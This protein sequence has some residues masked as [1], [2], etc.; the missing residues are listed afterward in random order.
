MAQVPLLFFAAAFTYVVSLG[1]GKMLIAHLGLK[2]Y[3]SEEYFFGFVLGSTILSTVVF[4][5]TAAHLA[6]TPVFL[7]AGLAIVALSAYRGAYRFSRERLPP[8]DISWR[9]ALGLLY[10]S[11]AILY[12]KTALLPEVQA[13]AVGYHI[14][15]PA[16]YLREHGFTPTQRNMMAN[17]SE[18]IEMLFT[19]A[20]AF[21]KH[22]AGAMVHLVYTLVLPFGIL[23]WGRRFALPEV[24]AAGA[25]L[26][27][28]SPIVGRLGT[29]GYID[30]AVA[31]IVFAVFYLLT[32][33]RENQSTSLLVAA[34]LLAG[35]CY[36]AKYTAGIAVP[37]AVGFVLFDRL[38]AR[39]PWW[40]PVLVT[41]L[42]AII[43]MAPYLVKNAV[44]TGNPFAPFA[45]R[46]FPNPAM[47]PS[48]EQAYWDAMAYWSGLKLSQLPL[49]V[50]VH[51]GHAAGIIGPVF[52][53]TPLALLAARF[54]AGRLLLLTGSVFLVPYVANIGTRFL[55]PA[56]PF[57]ALALA[58]AFGRWKAG[59]AALVLIHA[60]LSWPRIVPRYC[61]PWCWR[62][63]R[64]EWSSA[65][66]L[67]PEQDYLRSH[68][69]DYQMSQ[70]IE[71]IVPPGEFV[72]GM[73]GVAEAYQSHEI[74]VSWQSS[75]GDRLKTALLTPITTELQPVWHFRFEFPEKAVRKIRLLQQGSSP[76]SN[77]SVTELRVY[78]KGVEV[79]RESSW[80]PRTSH[81]P[82][83]LQSA[84]DNNPVTRW[85]SGEPLR[86]RMWLQLD[87]GNPE[88]I[89][90]VVVESSAD[91]PDTRMRLEFESA[92]GRWTALA[93]DPAMQATG[94]PPGL[95]AAAI[96]ALR[97][98]HVYWLLVK[99]RD[100]IADAVNPYP[101][102]WGLRLAAVDQDWRL[103]TL[104]RPVASNPDKIP[105]NLLV[106][107]L[108][109][110]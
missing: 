7:A 53:L 99:D 58:C 35:F 21:G 47:T 24:G 13:D 61:H 11:F 74:V 6:Y 42:F 20:F 85:N 26:L 103:Y 10:A 94:T 75:F 97:L 65:L 50:T 15:L 48:L 44:F 40:R 56:L 100:E 23:S 64:V 2:L 22:S 109:G 87:F 4:L 27:F 16:R 82:W 49:E 71:K 43:M 19:F 1:A 90:S 51:G 67:T 9:I 34:G 84:F 31:S 78:R 76:H 105:R 25:M 46:L 28:M 73:Q 95:R 63:E 80:T 98:N 17:L 79:P 68:R 36:A 102:S 86:P 88:R 54:R 69:S 14:A 93:G 37:F 45:N 8:L 107:V 70:L 89:D 104:G 38:R 96:D 33:W 12:L 72:F 30:V 66:R 77:W 108:F 18:G 3:R 32:I 60:F 92:P 29:T 62:L 5:L 57:F 106:S 39:K 110:P 59:I 41:G 91:Q 83:E 55:M 52:L 101:E 81:N